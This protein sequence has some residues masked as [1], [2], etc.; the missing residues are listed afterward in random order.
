MWPTSL[1]IGARR[2]SVW[3]RRAIVAVRRVRI[4]AGL[5]AVGLAPIGARHRAAGRRGVIG[6]EG[7]GVQVAGNSRSTWVKASPLAWRLDPSP[8]AHGLD[9]S[10]YASFTS[11]A[12]S[13]LACPNIGG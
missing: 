5:V 6:G 12:G 2:I 7:R 8:L 13:R 10:P 4:V 3:A 11:K 1:A 9:P